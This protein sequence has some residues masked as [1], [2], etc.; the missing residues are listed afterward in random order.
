MNP[1]SNV[2]ALA[3]LFDI[4]CLS[5]P[6]FNT[7]QEDAFNVWNSCPDTDP[8][9]PATAQA[10]HSAFNVSVDCQHYFVKNSTGSNL[11][12][13]WDCTTSG[14]FSGDSN[15]IIFA[16]KVG[17]APSPDGPQN[18]DLVELRKDAGGLANT[19]YRLNTVDGQA[20]GNVSS[21]GTNPIQS[22]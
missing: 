16:H 9:G 17:T 18:I 21:F 15:A 1:F 11:E 22:M 20:P 3:Q 10:M 14:Q 13:V 19:V 2:G 5:T 12:A 6:E 8:F 7:I 4:S